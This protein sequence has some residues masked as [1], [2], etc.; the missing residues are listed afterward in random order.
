MG[1]PVDGDRPLVHG[2]QQGGLSFGRGA[3]DFVGQQNLREN[4]PLGQNK[5]IGLKIEQIGAQHVAGHQ[6]GGEL[7]APEPQ[8]ET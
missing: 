4:G 3:V 7:D 1:L 2:L 6:I 5:G 8:I